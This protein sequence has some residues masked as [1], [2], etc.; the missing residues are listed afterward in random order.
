[1]STIQ[2][3]R[4]WKRF[5]DDVV[6]IWRGTKRAFDI[7]VK[8]L[9]SE[10]KKYGIEF[11]VDEIQFGRSVHTLDLCAWLDEN[12]RIQYKGYSKPTDAKRYLNP[13]SF[14]PKS[15]FN[16]IPFSQMLRTIR[17]NSKPETATAELDLLM[18]HFKSSGYKK[19]ILEE[20]KLKAQ[21]RTN[22][23]INNQE[24]N[25]IVF[26]VHFFD[27]VQ[28]LKKVIRSLENEFRQLD[29]RCT[30][31]VCNEEEKFHRKLSCS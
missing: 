1:M 9:N 13:N 2:A 26:P 28:E 17:N 25:S 10:T 8:Q 5:I 29:W 7:F 14:H 21:N 20:L 19:E 30:Y 16:A 6:G 12:N 23:N 18:N 24:S 4:F 31:Y 11:P 27:G 3:I 15:V 22:D